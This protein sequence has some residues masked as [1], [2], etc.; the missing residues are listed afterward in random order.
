MQVLA[1]ISALI[2]NLAYLTQRAYSAGAKDE[3]LARFMLDDAFSR[4]GRHFT[5]WGGEG[6]WSEHVF[7]RIP[8]R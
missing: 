6:T 8:K 3:K 2:G 4:I 1:K 7:S 5:I